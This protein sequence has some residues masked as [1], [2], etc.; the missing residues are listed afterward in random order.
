MKRQPTEW[1]DIFANNTAE[2][3]FT[4]KIYKEILNL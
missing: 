1:D 4:S 3:V 2:K